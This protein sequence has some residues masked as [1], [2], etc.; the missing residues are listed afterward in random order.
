V[1]KR[2]FPLS[3]RLNF[4]QKDE[5]AHLKDELIQLKLRHATELKQVVEAGKAELDHAKKELEELHI[6]EIKKVQDQLH[7]ELKS[8]RDLRELERVATK[9]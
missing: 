8:K 5:T 7:G 3:I 6:R 4:K 1:K 9:L 2:L